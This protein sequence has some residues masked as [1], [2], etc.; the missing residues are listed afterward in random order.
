MLTGNEDRETVVLHFFAVPLV[1]RY[2][3]FLPQKWENMI[4]MRVEIYGCGLSK[5]INS[6]YCNGEGE[7]LQFLLGAPSSDTQTHTHTMQKQSFDLAVF[8]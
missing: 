8:V 3:R 7:S 2:L 5:F 1:T 6:S 4:C